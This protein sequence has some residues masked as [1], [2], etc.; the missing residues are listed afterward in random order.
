MP[1]ITLNYVR[2]TNHRISGRAHTTEN[3]IV[4]IDFLGLNDTTEANRSFPTSPFSKCPF[5]VA[6]RGFVLATRHGLHPHRAAPLAAQSREKQ[7][8]T[9]F[10]AAGRGPPHRLTRPD[11]LGRKGV[12][13]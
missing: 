2:E 10:V 8:G 12:L 6:P 9:G 5:A 13:D 3:S 7:A 4:R 11:L 1:I